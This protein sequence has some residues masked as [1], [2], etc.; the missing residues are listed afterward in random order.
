MPHRCNN[1][2]RY[3]NTSHVPI[4]GERGLRTPPLL[5]EAKYPK[6]VKVIDAELA[7]V[8]LTPH[9]FRAVGELAQEVHVR[10]YVIEQLRRAEIIISECSMSV[11]PSKLSLQ[12]A[13]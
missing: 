10:L 4:Y 12:N 9:T 3:E 13:V 7:T 6:G 5:D 11:E 1:Q 8:N 2:K